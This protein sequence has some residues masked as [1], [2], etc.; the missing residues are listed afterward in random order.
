MPLLPAVTLAEKL[1]EQE[2]KII[3]AALAESKAE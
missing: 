1:H 2:T 3:E